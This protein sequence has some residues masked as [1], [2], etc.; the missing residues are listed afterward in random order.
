MKEMI[1]DQY[2]SNKDK[3]GNVYKKRYWKSFQRGLDS[4]C[5]PKKADILD[6]F[7]FTNKDINEKTYLRFV[8]ELLMLD[9]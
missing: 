7:E 8:K 4:I 3:D 1:M 2:L 9:S 6:A 5:N